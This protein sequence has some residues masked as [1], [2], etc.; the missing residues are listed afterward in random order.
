MTNNNT[1]GLKRKDKK[2]R[3]L[4][5]GESQQSD[6]RYRFS[7]MLDGKQKSF[8]SWKLEKTDRLPAGKRDC[9]S[10][11]EK[12]KEIQQKLDRQLRPRDMTVLELCK[13]YMSIRDVSLK[14][15]SV[16][17]HKTAY[18]MLEKDAFGKRKIDSIRVSDAKDFFLKQQ[19]WGKGDSSSRSYSLRR[20]LRPAFQMAYEDQWIMQNPFD[21]KVSDITT[22]G[23]GK[24]EAIT[25]EQMNDFLDFVKEEETLRDY[26]EGMYILFHTGIRISEF[27]GLTAENVSLRKK[28]LTIDHQLIKYP[29]QNYVIEQPKTEKGIRKLP[30]TD[31]VAECFKTLIKKAKKRKTQPCVDGKSGFFYLLRNDHPA[32]ACDWNRYFKKSL[33]KYNKA[34]KEQIP[35]ITPHICRHTYCSNMAKAGMNPKTLQYLMGHASI[36]VTLNVYAH[37]KFADAEKE[38]VR[39]AENSNYAKMESI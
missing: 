16:L 34:H 4:R 37:V 8:Y 11:R 22:A 12:E 2:G 6:G 39:I 32:T 3:I 15:N 24:R 18:N 20:I 9:I 7:Y 25:E 28:T 21:F 27:C 19:E 23:M 13:K 26:W 10:L 35:K 5:L 38:L 17:S 1:K 36:Q 29:T 14:R 31:E 33:T 30:I